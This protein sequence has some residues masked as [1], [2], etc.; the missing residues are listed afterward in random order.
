MPDAVFLICFGA[1]I[2]APE[3]DPEA[4]VPPREN[5]AFPRMR[6]SPLSYSC[7]IAYTYT[8]ATIPSRNSAVTKRAKTCLVS[9]VELSSPLFVFGRPCGFSNKGVCCSIHYSGKHSVRDE[10]AACRSS[11]IA[12]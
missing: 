7:R 8:T 12:V 3:S 11:R 10:V 5:L 9:S 6:W 1:G 4:D 2:E